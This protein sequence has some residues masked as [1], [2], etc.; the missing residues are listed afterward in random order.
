[1]TQKITVYHY[2]TW[3]PDEGLGK[4]PCRKRTQQQIEEMSG[5]PILVTREDVDE[6]DLALDGS[7]KPAR[8]DSSPDIV[9]ISPMPL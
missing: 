7:Y 5:I 6:A 8:A 9:Q 3:I 1:M 2:W 4:I